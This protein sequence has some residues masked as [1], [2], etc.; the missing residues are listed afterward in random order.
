MNIPELRELK[1]YPFHDVTAKVKA[2]AET[3]HVEFVDLLPAVED[4]SPDTLW[5]T[6]PDPHP[7]GRA[8]EL[9]GIYFS[10][11]L[12]RSSSHLELAE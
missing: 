2:A 11:H 5:V 4:L 3:H 12:L 9:M 6:K 7:N 10:N 1:E 8:Q